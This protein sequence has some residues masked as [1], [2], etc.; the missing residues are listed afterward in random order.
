MI[1][2]E[3]NHVDFVCQAIG[4]PTPNIVWYFNGGIIDLSDASKYGTSALLLDHKIL[5]ILLLIHIQS[6]DAG[7]YTCK[8]I[9]IVGIDKSSAILTVNGM[10]ILNAYIR[11]VNNLICVLPFHTA[12][13]KILEPSIRQTSYVEEGNDTI[14]RCVGKGYPPP[15]VKWRR[16][17][18]LLSGRTSTTSMSMLTNRGNETRVTVDLIFTGAHREDTDAYECSVSN[19]LNAVE[20]STNLI[21]QCMLHVQY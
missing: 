20:R 15:L 4:E 14:F 18:R 1:E 7:T 8:A 10:Y 19:L 12:A 9:N 11:S 5:S 3:T 17:N 2:N 13:A 6:S 21:V 16:E